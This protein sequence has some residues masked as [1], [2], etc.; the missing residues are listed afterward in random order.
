MTHGYRIRPTSV[1][2]LLVRGYQ[3]TKQLSA[4]VYHPSAAGRFG[5][6]QIALQQ[7]RISRPGQRT[8]HCAHNSERDRWLFRAPRRSAQHPSTDSGLCVRHFDRG[9]FLPFRL[10]QRQAGVL[11]Q[12]AKAG[13]SLVSAG[14][15]DAD[16]RIGCSVDRRHDQLV[17][18]CDTGTNGDGWFCL[19]VGLAIGPL[20][21]R[22]Y[23]EALVGARVAHANGNRCG[24]QLADRFLQRRHFAGWRHDYA[25]GCQ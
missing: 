5:R 20:A 9:E 18:D 7:R 21:V 1:A 17:T 10:D 23:H 15:S 4:T 25:G 12:H 16:F 22:L 11:V 8:I 24:P 14:D 13:R 6:A 3:H 19:G 2:W